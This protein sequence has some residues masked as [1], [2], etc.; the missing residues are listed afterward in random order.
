MLLRSAEVQKLKPQKLP[1]IR[2]D[3]KYR[4][5]NIIMTPQRHFRYQ[6]NCMLSTEKEN[7]GFFFLISSGIT[8]W[9]ILYFNRS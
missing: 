6:K 9:N 8:H 1:D 7:S 3:A 4:S 5:R 2:T